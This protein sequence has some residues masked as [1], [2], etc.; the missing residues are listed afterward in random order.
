MTETTEL[1]LSVRRRN[2]EVIAFDRG[3]IVRAIARAFL[4]DAN[5]VPRHA[6]AS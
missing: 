2:G 3:R 5:G 1:I 6:C 4:N